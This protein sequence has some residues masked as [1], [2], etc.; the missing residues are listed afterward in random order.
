[1]KRSLTAALFPLAMIAASI[2]ACGGAWAQSAPAQCNDFIR[3]R[4]EAQQR[5][6]AL[7]KATTSHKADRKEVCTLITRFSAAEENVLK[8]LVKNQTWCGIPEV[9]IKGAKTNH[10]QT[11]KFRKM[12]CAEAPK[13]KE[14]T[15]SDL[16][17]QPSV[18]TGSNTHTGRG[19]LD[20]LSGNPLDR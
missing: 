14:P 10:E 2:T 17:G 1:M 15:L 4:N 9:A 16:I 7:R 20:S 18:D 3:L 12:A 8:F 11:L 5:A 19:T 13:P 6:L